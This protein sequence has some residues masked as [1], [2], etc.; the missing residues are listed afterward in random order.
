MRPCERQRRPRRR[1]RRRRRRGA[2]VRER[3]ITRN[4]RRGGGGVL[5]INGA[6]RAPKTRGYFNAPPP[7][8]IPPAVADIPRLIPPILF[9][10]RRLIEARARA[11][12]PS[13]NPGARG[14]SSARENKILHG[15][16]WRAAPR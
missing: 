5:G 15:A 4:R 10:S 6:P 9:S 2:R 13:A 12:A 3:R 11:R 16:E 14:M 1:R 8:G 7:A